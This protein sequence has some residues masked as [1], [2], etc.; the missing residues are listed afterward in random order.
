MDFSNILGHV[1][2]QRKRGDLKS[3]KVLNNMVIMQHPIRFLVIFTYWSKLVTG[4]I[5][6]Y[7][8][9]K[10]LFKNHSNDKII[11][12]KINKNIIRL[13]LNFINYNGQCSELGRNIKY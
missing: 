13:V 3:Q 5:E 6:W 2:V 11:E 9:I 10:Q 4:I 8:R 1:D 12:M 7:K